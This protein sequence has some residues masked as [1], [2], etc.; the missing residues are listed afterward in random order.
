MFVAEAS[1]K[2]MALIAPVG[3]VELQRGCDAGDSV[4]QAHRSDPIAASLGLESSHI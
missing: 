1:D 2:L 4:W 3:A